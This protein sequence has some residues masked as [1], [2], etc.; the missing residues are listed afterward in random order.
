[1]NARRLWFAPALLLLAPALLSRAADDAYGDPLPEGAKARLGT[2]RLRT[3]TYAAPILSPDGKSL[4]AQ[5]SGGTVRLDP[6]TGAVQGKVPGQFYGTPSLLSADGKRAAQVG[7][8]RV[9]VWDVGTGKQLCKVERRIPGAEGGAALSSDGKVL[10]IGGV[11]ERVKKEAV[12]VLVWDVDADKELK[13]FTVPQNESSMVAVS[14]DGK[15]VASWGSHY[16][17]DAK[18]P[19]PETNPSRFVHFWDVATGKE[20]AKFKSGGYMP[21]TVAFAPDGSVAAVANNNSSIDL[22]APNGTSKHL[23]L[24][25]ARTGR[26]LA[27]S[28]D[29]AT[30][31]ATAEDGAIQRWKVSDGSRLST[32][33]PP[34]AGLYNTRVRALSADTAV[35]WAGRNSATLVWEVPSGKL[36]SPAGGHTGPVRGLAVSAD[37]KTAFTSADDGLSLQWDVATGKQS[38]AVTIKL[39]GTGFSSY[40]PAALF[41]PDLARALVRDTGGLGVHDLATGTQQFV[42][43]TPYEGFTSGAFS[44]DGSKVVVVG[45]SYDTKKTPARVTV[46]DAAAGKRLLNLELPGFGTVAATVTPDGKH[47]VTAGR[48]PAETGNGEFLITTWELATGAKKGEHK[49]DAGFSTPFVATA[50]DN[51]TAAVVTARGRLVSY[52]LTTGKV[53]K[54]YD[55]NGRTPGLAPVF[56][57]DG[58]KLAVAGQSDFSATQSAPLLVIDWESGDTKQTFTVTGG[59]PTALAFSRDGKLLL[60]GSPDTTATVWDVNK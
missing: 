32:T 57:A 25:R 9:T 18:A 50:A 11:G 35:A 37:G 59:T 48:K 12:T 23:L 49:E 4:Y 54:T 58:K 47:V 1:V 44:G 5:G 30:L 45:S 31:V 26:W 14:G 34:V 24:G 39:P 51:K 2:A 40:Q 17:P 46:W 42:I 29:G 8:D 41:A 7:Y 21:G 10:A 16:D 19:D 20:L 55:L 15:V 33:E 28:P 38:G 43:P 53:G 27:F 3:L 56:T 22:V 36:I 6:A 60:S 52:D 13:R